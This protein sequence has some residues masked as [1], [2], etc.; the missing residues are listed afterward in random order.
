MIHGLTNFKFVNNCFLYIRNCLKGVHSKSNK[1]YMFCLEMTRWLLRRFIIMGVDL[2]EVSFVAWHWPYTSCVNHL[3]IVFAEGV[4]EVPHLTVCGSGW[5]YPLS[6]LETLSYDPKC[7]YIKKKDMTVSEGNF[8]Q[9]SVMLYQ[10]NERCNK[11]VIVLWRL[12]QR[13]VLNYPPPPSG[14]LCISPK[15]WEIF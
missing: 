1:W 2:K 15:V 13:I 5:L 9:M 7:R 3:K 14:A 6:L 4:T 10:W 8:G 12:F 11:C